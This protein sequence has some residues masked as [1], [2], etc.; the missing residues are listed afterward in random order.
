LTADQCDELGLK[1]TLVVEKEEAEAYAI[2]R[3]A[4]ML[5]LPESNLGLGYA[6]QF[7]L[8]E[9][10]SRGY[11]RYW[12]IDDDTQSWAIASD[13][14]RFGSHL[15]PCDLKCAL[16][17]MESHH[18][19]EEV[20]PFIAGP[21]YLIWVRG[22]SKRGF[23]IDG[24]PSNVVLI[25][26]SRVS[27]GYRP[28]FVLRQDIAFF[29]DNLIGQPHEFALR[30]DDIGFRTPTMGSLVGGN[31][32]YYLDDRAKEP[33]LELAKD[34][35]LQISSYRSKNGD[36]RPKPDWHMIRKLRKIQRGELKL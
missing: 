9:A 16:E 30:F 26:P 33:C 24:M 28:H 15:I 11:E 35:P 31:A 13:D 4:T 5:I 3:D 8:D 25:D 14:E 18:S 36:Y 7:I 12:M 20:K 17:Y 22:K 34:Y 1:Y 2:N 29:M 10:R 6:R 21:K 23:T 19:L 32:Q 27:T